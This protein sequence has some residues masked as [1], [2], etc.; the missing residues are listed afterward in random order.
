MTSKKS[1]LHKLKTEARTFVK[2][3]PTVLDIVAFGSWIRGKD[4]AAD[5]D[6]LLIYASEKNIAIPH[7]IRKRLQQIDKRVSIIDKTYAELFSTAFQARE[8]F[9]TEGYSLLYARPL[10]EGLG[11][12]NYIMFKYTL[13][14]ANK[15]TRMRFYYALHGRGQEGI[16]KRT[17][18]TKFADTVLLCPIEHTQEMKE[19]LNAWNLPILEM[20]V[21]IP[22][23]LANFI[24]RTN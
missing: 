23:R 19:F 12:A 18:A 3:H 10:A 15:S 11:L 22:Q 13:G 2:T 20:P 9:I 8:A 4:D 14:D 24:A 17:R 5:I 6:I 1:L 7:R 21:L 16:L